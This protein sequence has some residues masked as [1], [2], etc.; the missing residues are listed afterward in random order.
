LVDDD[1]I[2]AKAG[3]MRRHLG[4]AE[5]KC[6]VDLE[7]FLGDPDRQDIVLFNLQMAIQN[8]IDMA[9][10]IVGDEGLGVPGSTSEMFYLL[11]DAGYL[12]AGLTDRMVRAVGFRNLLV[13][14]YGRLDMQLVY[15]ITKMSGKDLNDYLAA[16]FRRVGLGG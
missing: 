13:H 5:V 11:Q 8:C 2:L 6:G 10:H 14:E 9:A 3:L 15:E 7:S 12:D 4:R 16:I 1:L